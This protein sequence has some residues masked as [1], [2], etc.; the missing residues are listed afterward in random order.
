MGDS[1][2]P[3]TVNHFDTWDKCGIHHLKGFYMCV[4]FQLSSQG[5]TVNCSVTVQREKVSQTESNTD[6]SCTMITFI[7]LRQSGFLKKIVLQQ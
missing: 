2:P 7:H 1:R 6:M 4:I 5:Y 3:E